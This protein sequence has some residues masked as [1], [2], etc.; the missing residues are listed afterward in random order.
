MALET[1]GYSENSAK[2][3]WIHSG[4]IFKNLVFD[5]TK[6]EFSGTLLGA[7]DDGTEFKIETKYRKIKADG[8]THM[9]VKGLDVLDSA[10][11]NIKC[12]LKELTGENLRLAINGEKKDSIN[13]PGFEE[14]TS[15]REILE[16]DY[17]SNMGIVGKLMGSN[18]PIVVIIDNALVTSALSMKSKDNDEVSIDLELRATASI[19]QLHKDEFPWRILYPK[20]NT[21]SKEV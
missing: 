3:F 7:T 5:Q 20:S 10:E 1:S 8:T 19:E 21:V 2:S 15:K 14:I 4:T 6:K 9:S 12:K 17:I 11:A 13:Y 16:G 18:D